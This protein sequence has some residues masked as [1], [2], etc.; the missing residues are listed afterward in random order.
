MGRRV[1][2]GGS[3]RAVPTRRPWSMACAARSDPR[4]GQRCSWPQPLQWA[5][6]VA[7]LRWS[8]RKASDTSQ[9][10][11]DFSDMAG[12]WPAVGAKE[13]PRDEAGPIRESFARQAYHRPALK[14]KPRLSETGLGFLIVSSRGYR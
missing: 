4:F 3:L 13:K 10:S 9:A 6:T 12:S 11:L 5:P 1:T 2:P 8:C 14:K 7:I